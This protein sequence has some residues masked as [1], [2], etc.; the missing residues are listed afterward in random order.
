MDGDVRTATGAA[1]DEAEAEAEADTERCTACPGAPTAPAAVDAAVD[2]AVAVAAPLAEAVAAVPTR[3]RRTAA[4]AAGAAGAVEAWA[5]VRTVGAFIPVGAEAGDRTA[6]W[7]PRTPGSTAAPGAAAR[8]TEARE[9]A[10]TGAGAEA[11]AA[12]C[13]PARDGE[14][15]PAAVTGREEPTSG[16]ACSDRDTDTTGASADDRVTADD[17]PADGTARDGATGAPPA[18]AAGVAVPGA[19]DWGKVPGGVRSR[20]ARCTG[21][22]PTERPGP[23]TSFTTGRTG[24]PAT[25]P[26]TVPEA[27]R[28]PT[29]GTDRVEAAGEATGGAAGGTT[30]AASGRRVDPVGAAARCTGNAPT[31]R[32][33]SDADTEGVTEGGAP[34]V[35]RGAAGAGPGAAFTRAGAAGARAGDPEGPEEP[36][37]AGS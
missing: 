26:G 18:G 13:R 19:E 20:D 8:C 34:P 10:A 15:N 28:S 37:T 17:R 6:P 24:S 9:A 5:A 3:R 35:T 21:R 23:D 27:G 32:P 12:D 29:M 33:G 4:G 14:V 2:A 11:G 16:A 7:A 30:G 1:D 36:E 22:A 31:E 25:A